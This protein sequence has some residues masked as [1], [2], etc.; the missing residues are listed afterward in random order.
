V[1]GITAVRDG[2]NED[3]ITTPAGFTEHADLGTGI[4][5]ET[6]ISMAVHSIA[7]SAAG[8]QSY[9]TSWSVADAFGSLAFELEGVGAAASF[10][11]RSENFNTGLRR[12][13]VSPTS[14]APVDGS[15]PDQS[16]TSLQSALN[17][18]QPGDVLTIGAGDYFGTFSRSNLPGTPSEPV[19]IAEEV[20]GTVRIL[21]V[22]TAAFNGTQTWTNVSGDR[23]SAAIGNTYMA[24]HNGDFLPKYSS[25]TVLD[26]TSAN[27]NLKPV[28]GIAVSG[29]TLH[30]VLKGAVN[31]NGQ[32]I[33]IPAAESSNVI[34]F[35]NCDNLIWDGCQIEGG[36]RQSCI[37]IDSASANPMIRHVRSHTSRFI[38]RVGSNAIVEWCDYVLADRTKGGK[39]WMRECNTLNG[40]R[41]SHFDIIKGDLSDNGN[42]VYEGGIAVGAG[43][44][45]SNSEFRF[46][47]HIGV[48]DGQRFGEW[49]NSESH[50]S[51][52]DEVGD[53]GIQLE[54][55]NNSNDGDGNTVFF[56]RFRNSHGPV[57]SHQ[58]VTAANHTVIR[59]IAEVT[60]SAITS[61]E[62]MIKTIRTNQGSTIR[63][64]H[65]YMENNASASTRSPWYPF[66]TP[67]ATGRGSGGDEIDSFLNSI[68]VFEGDASPSLPQA[69]GSPSDA[70]GNAWVGPTAETSIQGDN[71]VHAGT[72]KADLDMNADFTLQSSSPAKGIG[73]SLPGGMFD[74]VT[75][76]NKNAD[77]GPYF[78][79]FVPGQDWPRP[80]DLTFKED[81]LPERWPVESTGGGS[82]GGGGG[83]S[84]GTPFPATVF[85]GAFA[86]WAIPASAIATHPNNGVLLQQFFD[87]VP[88]RI[89]INTD[90]FAPAFYD[91]ADA[92]VTANLQIS[93]PGFGNLSSA[94]TVPWNF[95]IMEP[96]TDADAFV[97]LVDFNTGLCYEFWQCSHNQ[98]ANTVTATSGNIIRAGIEA[99][100][101]GFANVLTKVNAYRPVRGCGIH[102]A[103]GPVLRSEI[104]AGLIP[105]AMTVVWPKPALNAFAAPAIRGI[106]NPGNGGGPERGFMGE[107]IVWDGLTDNDIQTWLLTLTS[108]IRGPLEIIANC[109][110]DYGFIGTDG[111]GNLVNKIGATQLENTRS[112]NWSDFGMNNSTTLQALHGLLEPN[113]NKARILQVPTHVDGN[114]ANTC[115]YP[116]VDYPPGHPCNGG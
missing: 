75:A 110:R 56:N 27:G 86:P 96:P 94:N 44:V 81:E 70:D 29:S 5:T 43:T 22:K 3:T 90:E 91:L 51:V 66:A 38:C 13:H 36:G 60:D 78:P 106:G 17:A 107:R 23:Y 49:V 95:S 7:K 80:F 58:N 85:G 55:D 54:D 104:D 79:G 26:A 12:L 76:G 45:N 61:H 97:V 21:N 113:L 9:A 111:G 24:V 71:G 62:F 57:I 77:A 89:N 88:G 50:R 53:D 40:A 46:N 63:H 41:G 1:I 37:S 73:Q 83:G 47:A 42:A 16:F 14:T 72:S 102:H 8:S 59:N 64:A 20:F 105:H 67:T 101:P 39:A 116:G 93:Q 15:T 65:W 109:V 31:P 112:G 69:A 18:L 11:L 114:Q 48:F 34:T 30:I 4:S 25:T 2:N 92:N 84:G 32:S 98:G 103:V 108:S 19:W 87:M 82:G 6:D 52:Y 10:D 68:V 100:S 74:P 99:N 28:Q 33:L 35:S 115:C